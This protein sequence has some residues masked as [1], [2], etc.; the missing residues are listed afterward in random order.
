MGL[1]CSAGLLGACALA[2]VE[3]G[4][5][6]RRLSENPRAAGNRS[7]LCCRAYGCHERE[8]GFWLDLDMSDSGSGKHPWDHMLELVKGAQASHPYGD[9]GL[10]VVLGL[11]VVGGLVQLEW[12]EYRLDQ[13]LADLSDYCERAPARLRSEALSWAY[14]C[15]AR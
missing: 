2:D 1:G 12:A 15:R 9:S 13:L 3:P 7:G 5:E 10:D 4:S 11:L 8:S 14:D 6:G